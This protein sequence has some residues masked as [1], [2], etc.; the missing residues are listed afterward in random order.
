MRNIEIKVRAPDPGRLTT[1][2][3]DELRARAAGVLEQRDVFLPSRSGR[4]KL[5]FQNDERPQLILYRRADEAG[6]RVSNY[7]IVAVEDGEAFLDVARQAWGLGAEVRKTRRLFWL[8]NIRVHLDQVDG[9]GCFIE[10]EAVV[11]EKHDERTCLEAAQRLL[12]V[13]GLDS[14]AAES[15]AYVDLLEQ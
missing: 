2:L 7:E 13:L 12:S 5:R 1:I 11:D 3:R 9:L 14:C 15:R 8:D 4:L 10:I 6:L